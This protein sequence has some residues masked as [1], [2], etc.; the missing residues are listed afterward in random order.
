MV[1]H[2]YGWP[3]HTQ[4]NQVKNLLSMDVKRTAPDIANS[5][6]QD[7]D[8]LHCVNAVADAQISVKVIFFQRGFSVHFEH[9]FLIF[10]R[11]YIKFASEWWPYLEY[12][13]FQHMK[14]KKICNRLIYYMTIFRSF[15]FSLYREPPGRLY[16]PLAPMYSCAFIF[17][18]YFFDCLGAR[19]SSAKLHAFIT[20]WLANISTTVEHDKRL[21]R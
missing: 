9:M 3:L 20:I 12:L 6:K 21:S 18:L 13:I 15:D 4:S 16:C 17:S 5:K 7:S 11:K 19:N 2:P 1:L 14:E 8:V 10:F